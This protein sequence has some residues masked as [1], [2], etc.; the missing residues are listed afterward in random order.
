MCDSDEQDNCNECTEFKCSFNPSA[1]DKTPS[2][3]VDDLFSFDRYCIGIIE[4]NSIRILP[5]IVSLD[6]AT[7]IVLVMRQINNQ[8][9]IILKHVGI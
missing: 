5:Y 6:Q 7:S 4:N 8:R 9:V 1:L 3:N 2:M